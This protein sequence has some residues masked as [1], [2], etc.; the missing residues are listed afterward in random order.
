MLARAWVAMLAR[1]FRR[2]PLLSGGREDCRLISSNYRECLMPGISGQ[3]AVFTM[4]AA[5]GMTEL[6]EKGQMD[7]F[8]SLPMAR[9]GVLI[10]QTFY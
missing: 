7:R 4:A 10:R 8:R 9:S 1:S 2:S 6:K 5:V 3:I